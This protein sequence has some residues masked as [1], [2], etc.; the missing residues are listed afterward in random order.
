MKLEVMKREDS[1]Q[2]S[3]RVVNAFYDKFKED[4]G[5][6]KETLQKLIKLLWLEES[7][8]FNMAVYVLKE[9]KEVVGAFAL[10]QKG[11]PNFSLSLIAKAAAA[12][13]HIG[14]KK[15]LLFAK[16][17]LKTSRSPRQGEVYV[18]FIAVKENQR[19]K[20]VGHRLMKEIE[21]LCKEGKAISKISL[22]VLKSN[23]RAKH[24]YE[25]FGYEEEAAHEL[26][27][28][29]FMVQNLK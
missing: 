3:E 27:D 18:D 25:K 14:F 20:H 21:K 5:L 26:K 6:P 17:G 1:K 16:A 13:K 7:T 11:K 23:D 9:E 15:A 22:F 19:G 2:V 24:L 4:T 29:I 28:Y 10:T 8:A 12:V